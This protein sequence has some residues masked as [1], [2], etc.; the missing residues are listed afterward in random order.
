MTEWHVTPD[1]I[2]NN[3]TD[4]LFNLMVN[5]LVERKGR[6]TSATKEKPSEPVVSERM[7]KAQTSG[8]GFIK[9]ET[10]DGD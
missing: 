4:E 2:V 7:F 1:Y 8:T 3:W 10:K 6:E 5:K 9:W